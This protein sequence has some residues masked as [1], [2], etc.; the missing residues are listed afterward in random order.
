MHQVMRMAFCTLLI[1]LLWSCGGRA[2][3]ERI[4]VVV[5]GTGISVIDMR[6]A[7]ARAPGSQQ[8]KPGAVLDAVIDE[9]LLA[10]KALKNKLETYPQ[11]AE[12]LRTARRQILAE[13]YT[14]QLIASASGEDKQAIRAYYQEHPHLFAGRRS[15]RVFELSVAAAAVD[16]D[17][18]KDKVQASRHL[19]DVADWLRSRN[20]AFYLG[21][22]TKLPEQI[23]PEFL[24]KLAAMRDG[25]I[26]VWQA[27]ERVSVIQL[28]QSEDAPLSEEDALPLIEKYLLANNRFASLTT[29]LKNLRAAARIDY[30]IDFDG[31]HPK[32]EQQVAAPVE[33]MLF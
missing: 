12:A 3:Q 6:A 20:I 11:V 18:V 19:S 10:Q 13:A 30:L 15:Y 25:E 16:A 28:V 33:L 22:N 5:N 31:T 29:T 27:G 32:P 1:P 24:P 9:E 17:A 8:S 4:A 21:A 7:M 26:Q 14:H 23:P 2:P